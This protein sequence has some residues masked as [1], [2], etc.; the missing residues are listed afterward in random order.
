MTK[1]FFLFFCLLNILLA[2]KYESFYDQP[3]MRYYYSYHPYKEYTRSFRDFNKRSLNESTPQVVNIVFKGESLKLVNC[4]HN[5]ITNHLNCV[6]PLTELNCTSIFDFKQ[7]ENT[8][9]EAYAFGKLSLS[10][11]G[12][13]TQYV[14]FKINPFN[15]I[16]S[17][18]STIVYGYTIPIYG[19]GIDIYVNVTQQP[20]ITETKLLSE[21]EYICFSELISILNESSFF[22]SMKIVSE[23]IGKTFKELI[24]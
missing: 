15:K 4:T 9:L 1:Q 23:K 19:Y 6:G 13:S 11:N 17:N 18:M 12:I 20:N 22:Y 14:K 21:D 24:F 7:L 10:K 5:S 16:E 2:E 8:Y 3:G